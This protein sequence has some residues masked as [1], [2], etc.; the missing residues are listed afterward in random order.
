VIVTQIRITCDSPRT[1][2]EAFPV[3][4]WAAD[5]AQAWKQARRAG[6]ERFYG[7]YLCPTHSPRGQVLDRIRDLAAKGLTD[8]AIG[9]RL[10]MTRGQIQYLRSTCGIQGQREGRP[11]GSTAVTR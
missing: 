4:G 2:P 3:A 5:R 11:S 8:N 6:W 10:G 9:K 1:C 7:Q